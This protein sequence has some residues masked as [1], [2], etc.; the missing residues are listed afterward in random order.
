MRAYETDSEAKRQFS[1]RKRA[2]LMNVESLIS[3]PLLSLQ[4]SV[5]IRHCLHWLVRVSGGLTN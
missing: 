3:G 1:D 5:R 4:C 2:V